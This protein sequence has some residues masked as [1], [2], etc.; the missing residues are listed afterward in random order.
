[1]PSAAS[2]RPFPDSSGCPFTLPPQLPKSEQQVSKQNLR[3]GEEPHTLFLPVDNALARMSD[4]ERAS[5]LRDPSALRN[6]IESHIVSGR[7]S[8][9]DLMRNGTLKTLN[10]KTLTLDLKDHRTVENATV[11]KTETA[12]NGVVHI[13]DAVIES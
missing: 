13:I 1:V 2:F 10:G 7:V 11:V 6:L 9:A 4:D 8:A 5:V 3:T 12:E